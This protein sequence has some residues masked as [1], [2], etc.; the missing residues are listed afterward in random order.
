MIWFGG[1][2]ISSSQ[3]DS[4]SSALTGLPSYFINALK[5]IKGWWTAQ[6][7]PGATQPAGTLTQKMQVRIARQAKFFAH[8]E[9]IAAK[10]AVSSVAH[11]AARKHVFV[12]HGRPR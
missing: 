12:A 9:A 8:A 3:V 10:S 6:T 1:Q 5:A 2:Q 7:A 11:H 4:S